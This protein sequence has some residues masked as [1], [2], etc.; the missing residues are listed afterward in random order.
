MSTDQVKQLITEA[1]NHVREQN[2]EKAVEIARQALEVDSRNYDAYGVLGVAFAR[3]GR[4]EEATDAFQR[5]VQTAP[6]S[7]RSYYNLG[8][9]YY[10][11]GEKADAISM[12]QEAIRCDGKHRGALELLK[13]LESETHVQVAPY[14]TSL[15]DAR[16][17]AYQYK[18]GELD[19][20]PP[21]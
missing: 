2:F 16:G 20:P 13:K 19:E 3:L 6:Y 4:I 21:F 8:M 12:C 7:A 1:S 14:Q 15:G 5:A 17:S 18:K 10:G 9:H 11:M